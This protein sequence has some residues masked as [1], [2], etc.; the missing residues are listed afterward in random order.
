[1]A[2]VEPTISES[3]TAQK[4]SSAQSSVGA[5]VAS[6]VTS[7]SSG[8]AIP[9]GGSAALQPRGGNPVELEEEIDFGTHYIIINGHKAHP[10]RLLA[11]FKSDAAVE[12]RSALLVPFD[13]R[14]KTEFALTPGI[15]VLD[16]TKG[17]LPPVANADDAKAR[18]EEMQDRIKA[19]LGTGRFDYV[20][21]DYIRTIQAVPSDA[22]FANGALWGLRNTGQ[23]GG[24]SGAD[25]DVVR[26]WD[27][28]TGSTNVIVAVIDTGIRYTHTDLAA[29]MWR[30]P[31]EIPGN[32]ID[33]D[34]DGYVDNVFGI[35][36]VTGSGDPMDVAGHGTHCA[37]TIGA[38]SN[39]GGQHV[40]VAWQVRLMACKFLGPSGGATSDAIKCINFAVSKG[41]R[42]L[43]NS[44][45]GGPFEQCLLD[46]IAA[47]RDRG[48]LFV[49]AAGNGGSDTQGDNNDVVPTYPAN[50]AIDNIISVAAI[51]RQDKLGT[52]SNY[53]STSVHIGAPGVDILS[54]IS[55]SDTSYDSWP[56][57][58]MATPHVAGVA[59]LVRARFPNI[60]VAELRQR[61]LLGAM[62]IPALRNKTITGGRLNAY[63]AVSGGSDGVL[64][65]AVTPANGA[66]LVGGTNIT[67]SVQVT[68]AHAVQNATVT[69]IIAGQSNVVFTNNGVSPDVT[70]N[71]H[72]YSASI[73]IPSAS[74]TFSLRIDVSAPG[75]TSSSATYTYP[76][77]LAP[78]ND[79]FA[80]RIVVTGNAATVTGSSVGATK[81]TGE[82]NHVG[83]LGGKSVWWTWTAPASGTATIKTD[84]CAFD[85]ILAVYSGTAVANLTAIAVDDDSGVGNASLVSFNAVGGV[86]YQIA[87]DGFD[88]AA[89]S[90]AL[91]VSL[92][93]TPSA[94]AN[95]N[96]ASGVAISGTTATVNGSNLGA[97]K[98]VGEPNHA[99]NTG[100]RSVW[101]RWTAPASGVA[102]VTTEG[103]LFDTTLGVYT[104]GS[105]AGLTTIASDNDSGEG[106][107]SLVVFN[108]TAG[109]TYQI[110]VDGF[111]GASGNILLG[112]SLVIPP[113]APAN[114]NFANRVSI[115]GANSSATGTNV[116][117]TKEVGEADHAG[118]SGG[119]SVWWSWTAPSSGTATITTT[120]SG[121]DTLLAV[122]TGSAVSALTLIGGNDQDPA[123]GNTSRATFSA[124]AGIAYHFGVDGANTGLVIATGNVALNVSLSAAQVAPTN[125]SFVNRT[126]IT[127]S[128]VAVVGSN[129]GATKE[130]SEPSH[131]GNVGGRS[132]WWSWTAPSNGVA[133]IKTEG[134]SLDTLLGVYTG[135]AVSAL[136]MVAQNDDAGI[137]ATTSMVNF[138]AVSGVAYRIAVDGFLGGSGAIALNIGLVVGLPAPANDAFMNRVAITG[139]SGTVTGTNNGATKE[140]GEANHADDPGGRSVWWSWTAP[141]TG[142]L[143][144][145]TSGSSFDTLLAIYKGTSIGAL[146]LVAADDE[147]GANHTSV[148]S[149]FVTAG[150]AYAIVVDGWAGF[151]GSIAVDLSFVPTS[152]LY[153]TDFD[154]FPAGN[155]RLAGFDGWLSTNT[156]D[157]VSGIF[158]GFGTSRTGFLGFNPTQA[159]GVFVWR[160][161][162]YNPVSSGTPWVY[163]VVDIEV[164]DSTNGRWD[165]FEFRLY[166]Q[167]VQS[168][169]AIVFD[170][171]NLRVYRDDGVASSE[172]GS[173]A[174]GVRYQMF[175]LM[176]FELNLW[177]ASLNGVTLFSGPVINAQGSALNLGDID[178]GWRIATP[179]SPGNNYLIFD[180]YRIAVVEAPTITT[181][182][183][184]RTVSIGQA[185]TFSVAASASPTPSFQWQRQA[186][187][188]TGFVNVANGAIFSGVSTNVLTVGATTLAMSGDQFRCVAG[189]GMPPNATSN[190]ATLTI[191]AANSAPT[192]SDI[193]NQTVNEDTATSALT[194][195]VGDAQTSAASLIVAHSSSNPTLVP[196]ADIV[197]GGSGANRTVTVTP[198]ENQSG[199]ATIT[200]TV[201]DGALTASDTFV[202]TVNAVNDAPT[203]GDISNQTVSEDTATGALAFTVGDVETAAA[204][205]LVA[206]SSSNPTLVPTANIVFGGSG[207][208]RTVTVTPA[209]NQSG[210]ATITITVSDGALT[211][212]DTFVLTV[213][214]V[215]DAPTISDIA[216]QTVNPG[217]NIGLLAFTVGDIETAS[218]SLTVSGSSSNATLVPNANIVV[219]GSGANRTVTVTPVANQSGVA[220]ITVTVSDGVL[221]A[222][223]T[224]IIE[225]R[226]VAFAA[227][228][229]VV[230]AGYV[231]GGTVTIANTFSYTGGFSGLAYQVLLP[232]GWSLASSS[233]D[234][235]GTK[236]VVGT[237]G[238]LEWL[239]PVLP[240]SPSSFGY[241][242][243]VPAGTTG[244]RTISAMVAVQA[245]GAPVQLLVQP[246]P[247]VIGYRHSAD[248]DRDNKISLLE[249]TRVIELYNVRS[250]TT[251]TGYYGV[252]VTTS[253][254]GFAPEPTRSGGAVVTLTNYHSADTNRDGRFSLLELT[255]VI[256]LYNV[257]SGSV[258]TGAYRVLA[259]SEDGFSPG[260]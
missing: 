109:T 169:G 123:G 106:A 69:G 74:T 257:R 151:S 31:G 245:G 249:L 67:F 251:R 188:S 88:G 198:A 167:A 231:P 137:G 3:V 180:N 244:D 211:A 121:F 170:N 194:F 59:A 97:T 147:S 33:D 53:G 232:T 102:V 55:A 253:E 90:I 175:V 218:A 159:A 63:N 133:T 19:L 192:I 145:T 168:L 143:T 174:N 209:E 219:G 221:T 224:F 135:S 122:Y 50:Y 57:T 144:L 229:T 46:A 187:G 23:N 108:A 17:T 49:A 171:Q 119:R 126:A 15:V 242:L 241:T 248:T 125:D 206:G 163:F 235:G 18:G 1:M 220:T 225:V 104:G 25:I 212:G 254:D 64:E 230:G 256:E 255:R 110:A 182:P 202:L 156:T 148:V 86:V 37:G 172:V 73:A 29:Q 98:Q 223:D 196:S 62:P 184:N 136:T 186:V 153:A 56:G 205:L 94:P 4:S 22:A 203:I 243:N 96:F 131:G 113:P 7:V 95:D 103:S 42:I 158:P 210:T 105:V 124:T 71:D 82:P 233:G 27:L 28:T 75:K 252:A 213:K 10:R 115:S 65:L 216:N 32:G 118:N 155:D 117:A 87:V 162:N 222:V 236:P 52:F 160:P 12:T 120:G 215:N 152:E 189:N 161:I 128:S 179:G 89:G 240:G 43:S 91:D 21:P 207:S 48:V 70:A 24:V 183:A 99:G 16:S 85:T 68:D 173:F 146:T 14:V 8:N 39:G 116:G 34:H 228:H 157:G 5:A 258:R 77:R 177:A 112:L 114:N 181:Q 195:T 11:K 227:T 58:S 138:N 129:V 41:A 237:T 60:T 80:Q 166:N 200:V 134:S 61:I 234:G 26:A 250:G 204:S 100:G 176:N 79:A 127:G 44:W 36:A 226:A 164:R 20:E 93:A 2:G 92:I 201:S 38:T 47:A 111:N 217:A 190:V 78:A 140:I 141:Q 197:F 132:V 165:K 9:A 139:V 259:G 208:N 150:T 30:N 107:R 45:G 142:R 81:E 6:G 130:A 247:L 178:V 154:A 66:E 76:V 101:W 185:A 199:T 54:A 214:A 193:A 40:G 238:L 260:P 35:N 83:N 191:N 246:D 72:I 149:A 13:L 84:G 51:D 239:W